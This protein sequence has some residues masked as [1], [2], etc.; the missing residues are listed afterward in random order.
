MAQQTIGIGTV[1][2]DGTGD[3]LRTAFTKANAN[4]TELYAGLVGLLDFKGATDASA[5]PNYPAASKG[6]FYLVSVAG[7]IGGAS[8]VVVEAKDAYFATA[9][10]AGGTDAAVGTSWTVIQGNTSGGGGTIAIDDEGVEELAAAARLNFTGSGVSV[11]VAGST[12][13]VIIPGGGGSFVLND[14]T[15]VNTAGVADGNVLT[16]ES[17]TSEWLPAAPSGG[18]SYEAGPPTPATT[19]DLGTWVN[20]GTSTVSDGTGALILKPQIDGAIHAREK[21]APA[22]PFDLYMKV[23]FDFLSTA[24]V[25]TAISGIAGILLRDSAD[26]ETLACGIYYERVTGDEQPL[27]GAILQRWT[28]ATTFSATPILKYGSKPWKWIRANVTSTTVTL[29]VSQ[30][31]KNWTQVGTETITTFVDNI[32]RIGVLG[33]ASA[34][35]TEAV[36][37]VPYFSTTAPS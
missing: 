34:N 23:D 30:D 33:I 27:F 22:A 32:D 11:T 15:D 35:A 3:P 1:A 9:D 10:N 6:D 12:A 36:I 24:A 29:Y 31:G 17:T 28:N 5:N 37:T 20:Q 26:S 2:N 8:G 14:A 25:T 16:Y 21:V 18:S 19:T 13:E 7:K 4:F